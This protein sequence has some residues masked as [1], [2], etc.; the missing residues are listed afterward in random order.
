MRFIATN[1][2]SVILGH[3]CSCCGSPVLSV[4]R[5]A[6]KASTYVPPKQNHKVR[7]QITRYAAQKAVLEAIRK[8]ELCKKAYTTAGVALEKEVVEHKICLC[9]MVVEA[10]GQG[11]P[12]CGS[13]EPW[14]PAKLSKKYLRELEEENFP[15]VFETYPEAEAWALKA[16][17][18]RIKQMET[19][20]QSPEVR[21]EAEKRAATLLERI[22]ALEAED[23]ALPEHGKEIAL[24]EEKKACMLRKE[25]LSR[26][27]IRGRID[28]NQKL[29]GITY[30]L[31]K[32]REALAEK[33]AGLHRQL[34]ECKAMLKNQQALLYGCTGGTVKRKQEEAIAFQM[35]INAPAKQQA[36]L[37]DQQDSRLS[38]KSISKFYILP[39]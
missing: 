28:A 12:N 21:E 22:H 19:E 25:Q 38:A 10:F 15:S 33:Q 5:A 13:C 29:R 1:R 23:A 37:P 6:A 4:F 3:I 17:E 39:L 24:E 36:A 34:Q 7:E 26:W 20:R 2:K 18:A 27:D 9:H 32:N 11:C 14:M 30:R 31:N 35:E 16:N 8:V